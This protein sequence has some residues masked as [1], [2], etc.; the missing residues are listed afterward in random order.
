[1]LASI[2]GNGWALIGAALAVA[3]AGCGSAVGVGIAGQAASGVVTED[4]DKFARVLIMQLLPDTQGI[5]GL[6]VSFI[7]LSKI[8][9]LGGGMGDLEAGDGLMILAACLPIALAGLVSA[10]YQGRTSAAAIGIIAKKPDQFG[11][12]MLFP[13]MVE[14]YAIL[15]LLISILAVTS[16]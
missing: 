13:A 9:L 15:S 1:M 4:P 8:G 3:L 5:Y 2:S 14:T 16:L 6:L 7:V 12:A 11:R 10:I